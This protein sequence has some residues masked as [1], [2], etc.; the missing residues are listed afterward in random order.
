LHE[1]R[2][3]YVLNRWVIINTER[4]KRPQDFKK[5]RPKVKEEGPCPFCPGNEKMTPPE[6]SRIEENIAFS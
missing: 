2:K 6:I 3:S 4:A 5:E 1:L